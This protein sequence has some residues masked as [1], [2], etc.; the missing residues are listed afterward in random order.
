MLLHIN[1]TD[2]KNIICYPYLRQKIFIAH[3]GATL[4]LKIYISINHLQ[5]RRASSPGRKGSRELKE[6]GGYGKLRRG[7]GRGSSEEPEVGREGRGITCITV[8]YGLIQLFHI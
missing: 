1:K 8:L 3:K 4:C 6:G 5:A 2:N 7:V